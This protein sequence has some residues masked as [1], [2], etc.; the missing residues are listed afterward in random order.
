[1]LSGLKEEENLIPTITGFLG[2]N[3]QF[4]VINQKIYEQT[5]QKN[6]KHTKLSEI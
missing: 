6:P 5:K 2:S 1:M 3:V 4:S